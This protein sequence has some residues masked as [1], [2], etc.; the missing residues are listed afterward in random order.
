MNNLITNMEKTKAMLFHGS[1]SSL[2]HRPILYLNNK[3]I[4]YLSN[5]K[6]L[7]IYHRKLKLGHSCTMPLSKIKQSSLFH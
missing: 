5:L 1:G 6:F 2:I 4:T 3:E 7:A